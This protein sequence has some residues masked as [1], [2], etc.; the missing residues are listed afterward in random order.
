MIS[1]GME[2]AAKGMMSLIDAQDVL[3]HNLAN[4]NTTG[5]K[6]EAL[7]F[8]SVYNAML[9]ESQ[10]P[11]DYKYRNSEDIGRISM[12]S[13]THKLVHEF[14]QGTITKTGVPLDLAIQGDGFFKVQDRDGNI[15]YTR[16]GT[17]MI[18]SQNLLV[19]SEG[20]YVLD[21]ENRP[22]QLNIRA[23]GIT[24]PKD[25]T[26]NEDGLISIVRD[27]GNGNTNLQRIGVWDF[28]NKEDM[29]SLGKAKYI[30][31]D[32]ELNPELPSEKF[33]IEQGALEL[34]NTNVVNE[35]INS[36]NVSRN[37]ETLSKF[38]KEKASHISAAI[39]VGR[40]RG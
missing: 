37:Y 30:P 6:K 15:A 38:I 40:L 13:Q 22:I 10:T 14:L 23:L 20:C 19:D 36:I 34:S 35:M 29:I 33:V 31:K 4:V 24:T 39:N 7:T 3:A 28:S 1:R 5:Y 11:S 17:F 26:I 32:T 18:N 27:G 8:K 9:S 25:L 21:V 16:N 12:G 2:I